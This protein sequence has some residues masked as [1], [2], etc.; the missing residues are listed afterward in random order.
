MEQLLRKP[1]KFPKL[2]LKQKREDI[3]NYNI[4]DFVLEKYNYCSKIN[5]NMK[6]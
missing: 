1:K 2:Y 4:N 3:N 5:M 6:E